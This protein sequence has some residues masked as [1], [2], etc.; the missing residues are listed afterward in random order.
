MIS[1]VVIS[2]E[3]VVSGELAEKDDKSIS[4]QISEIIDFISSF[5][6]HK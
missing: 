2:G 5:E 4:S 3:L 6:L 1:F